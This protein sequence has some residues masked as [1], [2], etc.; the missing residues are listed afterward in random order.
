MTPGII[1]AAPHSGAGKTTVAIGLMAAFARAGFRVAPAK[2]GPDYIDPR[3][4][5]FSAGRVSANLDG[6]AMR[7]ELLDT[8]IEGLSADADLIVAEGVMGLFDGAAKAGACDTGTTADLAE[9]T[10]WPVVLVVDAARQAQSIAALVSGFARFRSGVAVAGVILNRVGSD[11][12][13]K[14]LTDALDAIAMPVFGAIPRNSAI[15]RPS[16]HLGLEQAAEFSEIGT[17]VDG[18][19]ELIGL[20]VD[21]NRVRKAAL[22]SDI[23]STK[24]Q[25][26]PP[27]G[28]RIAV[29]RDAAFG[30]SYPHI[31]DGWRSAG[32]ELSFFAPLNDEPP[33][34][35]ADAIFLPGG[36][37]ELH[38][39][40]LAS[41]HRFRGGVL[42]AA[43]RGA[44]VYG[45]CGGYM[46]LGRY[47]CGC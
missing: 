6:W 29:A 7:P 10:G 16:R 38:A 21:L 37:P 13:A 15:E 3:F 9:R 33:D 45:E 46:V 39:G 22:A 12:H 40:R 24:V 25:I 2:V 44:W 41:N 43:E 31:L 17:F 28:Q 8:L 4:H 36:Y 11:R 47:P 19:A 35:K 27:L 34:D 26:L 42:K 1:I 23:R 30:F 18:V 32:A 14:V 5:D 20:S